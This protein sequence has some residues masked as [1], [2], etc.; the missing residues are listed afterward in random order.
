ME[1]RLE[2]AIESEVTGFIGIQELQFELLQEG[3][4]GD[5][6]GK[7]HMGYYGD[8]RNLDY[9]S[10]GQTQNQTYSVQCVVERI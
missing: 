5:Y 8:A 10:N 7:Y 4:I 6:M 9:N 3:Y 1:K 2:H